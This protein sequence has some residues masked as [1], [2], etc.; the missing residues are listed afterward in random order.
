M[1]RTKRNNLIALVIAL[2]CGIALGLAVAAIADAKLY[3]GTAKLEQKLLAR[4]YAR[5]IGVD[6]NTVKVENCRP[7]AQP[8]TKVSC[9]VSLPTTQEGLCVLIRFTGVTKLQ[10]GGYG[11]ALTNFRKI[12]C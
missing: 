6:P 9:T 4:K 8:T 1:I 2:M 3:V 7:N 12:E 10:R 5:S 11:T